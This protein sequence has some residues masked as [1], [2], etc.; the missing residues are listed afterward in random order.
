MS[1]EELEGRGE[2]RVGDMS[3]DVERVTNAE[4]GVNEFRANLGQCFIG[5]R[6]TVTIVVVGAAAL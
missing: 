3:R 2:R 4:E 1:E 6:E 5:H